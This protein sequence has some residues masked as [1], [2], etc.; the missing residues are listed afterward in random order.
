MDLPNEAPAAEAETGAEISTPEVTNDAPQ[1]AV[2]GAAASKEPAPAA[3]AADGPKEPFWYRKELREKEKR[4]KNLER[5][6]EQAAAQQQHRPVQFP[7]PLSDVE[8]FQGFLQQQLQHIAMTQRLETS[9][10]FARQKFGDDAW[11]ETNEWLLTRPD[12]A[13]WA[14]NQ[15]DP[16]GAAIQQYRKEKLASEIGDNPDAWREKER[17]RLKAELLAELQAGQPGARQPATQ[18]PRSIAGARNVAPSTPAPDDRPV[19]AKD[20]R[21]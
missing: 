14:R 18:I 16:W 20:V 11:E 12:V 10:M 21:R 8:G 7:D 3:P 9:E 6:L 17:E 2:E 19:F 1:A 4:L 5:Q 13:E 15:R